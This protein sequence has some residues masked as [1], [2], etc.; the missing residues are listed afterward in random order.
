MIPIYGFMKKNYRDETGRK[1]MR[2]NR[3]DYNELE[4]MR[5]R[6]KESGAMTNKSSAMTK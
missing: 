6:T 4:T 5:N 2:I 3:Q 1:P